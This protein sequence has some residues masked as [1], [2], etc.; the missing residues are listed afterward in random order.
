MPILSAL[1]LL[2]VL[3]VLELVVT[4]GLA[5]DVRHLSVAELRG[6]EAGSGE[7]VSTE[8][9]V[10]YHDPLWNFMFVTDQGAGFFIA[11]AD[12]DFTFGDR[13]RIQ[14]SIA[15]GH[16]QPIFAEDSELTKIGEVDLPDP[17]LVDLKDW[18]WRGGFADPRSTGWIELQGV[19]EQVTLIGDTARLWC[20]GEDNGLFPVTIGEALSV[21]QAW[22]LS[23][24]RISIR[25]ALG[26]LLDDK[27][28]IHSSLLLSQNLSLLKVL[29]AG[30]PGPQPQRRSVGIR[31]LRPDANQN[32]IGCGQVTLAAADHLYVDD[33]AGAK[34]MAVVSSF[35][36]P[37]ASFVEVLGTVEADDHWRARVVCPGNTSLSIWPQRVDLGELASIPQGVRI[38]LQGE[39]QSYDSETGELVLSEGGKKAVVQ[40]PPAAGVKAEDHV[41][42]LASLDLQTARRIE[43]VGVVEDP[44]NAVVG[45][46]GEDAIEV[47]DRRFVLSPADLTRLF[48]GLG[49]VALLAT[50]F[51][52]YLRRTV[53]SRTRE[54][55]NVTA[56][57]R[58]SYDSVE[59]GIVAVGNQGEILAVNQRANSLLGLELKPGDPATDFIRRWDSLTEDSSPLFEMASA[60]RG[61]QGPARCELRL[62]DQLNSTVEVVLA[63]INRDGDHLG[64][65]WVLRDETQL[66]TLQADL[67]QAQKME[68]IGTL[69]GGVAHDFNNLLTGIIGNLEMLRFDFA[70]SGEALSYVEAAEAASFSA[71]ELVHQLLD[72]SRKSAVETKV[73]PPEDVIR[74][75]K[76]LLRHGFDAS[77]AFDFKVIQDLPA[78]K[79][80]PRQIEQ[81]LLNLCVNARDAMPDGGTITIGV[82]P[83]VLKEKMAV[84][85][86]VRDTGSGIPEDVKAKIFE[87]FFTTKDVG[88]GTGLGLSTSFG[89]VQRHE[90]E[91]RCDSTVGVGTEF[92]ILL[93]TAP[94]EEVVRAREDIPDS[95]LHGTET[96]LVID[97]E[98]V[99]RST[100]AS[101]L[102]HGGYTALTAEGGAAGLQ[103]LEQDPDAID[104]VLLDVTMPEMSGHQVLRR[105]RKRHPDKPVVMCSGYDL[106]REA[107]ENHPDHFVAK[108]FRSKDL[109]RTIRSVLDSEPGATPERGGYFL[110]PDRS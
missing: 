46:A 66:R 50:L 72:M 28:K 104:L 90:G 42:A 63:P 82:E 7:V 4:L 57:L 23:G 22:N 38:T 71:G 27:N 103:L 110:R 31:H 29:Q 89:I 41:D 34:S 101:L 92:R 62:R 106:K 98:W 99:V 30:D 83:D 61:E 36:T 96:I 47:L 91:L 24:S 20:R 19:V 49:L 97:D 25:G 52:M 109:M 3:V 84:A 107:I 32:F 64:N 54:L 55:S 80:D 94:R 44:A 35:E 100:A 58:A 75:L 56:Q 76:P 33:G 10:C 12:A 68:A 74:D 1:K 37:E 85:I 17:P 105:M 79:A 14:G 5:Q 2:P 70:T 108:P 11:P 60:F 53:A 67:L 18:S 6:L 102:S 48:F 69:A 81:V 65:L 8:A 78:V 16:G 86:Y 40:L 43:L 88:K 59:S 87:P 9:T 95:L 93:P 51:L 39:V 13:L 73:I 77:I 45:V 15:S 21:E 26:I